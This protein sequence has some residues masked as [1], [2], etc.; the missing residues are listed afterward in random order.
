MF[1]LMF[2]LACGP[3]F[4]LPTAS[5]AQQQS[6]SSEKLV[7]VN[8]NDVAWSAAADGSLSKGMRWRTL[9]GK[10]G[11]FGEGLPDENLYFRQGEMEPGTI[12]PA[13]RHPSPEAWYFISG[14]AK[15]V[16]DGEEF[17]AEPGSAV[18]L[19]PNAVSSVEIVSKDIA[20]IV[21][22]NWGINCDRGVLTNKKY[23]FLGNKNWPQTPRSRLPQWDYTADTTR[24]PVPG[25]GNSNLGTPL[26]PASSIHLKHVNYHDV[27]W[28]E[29]HGAPG[30]TFPLRWITLV[31]D[32]GTSYA[33]W[34]KGLP[35]EDV[36]FGVGEAGSTA[37]Y[38]DHKHD[39]P[40]FYY[41]VSGRLLVKVDGHEFIAEP[42]ELIYHK[43]WAVHRS[44]VVSKSTA[45]TLW[46]DWGIKCDQGVLKQPYKMLG[47]F[48]EQ[49][50]HAKLP[51]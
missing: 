1:K 36:L 31:G 5:I 39:V 11:Y 22:I 41:V 25:T 2:C 33:G 48:P 4:L 49:P 32:V 6:E 13:H 37:V 47:A 20:Q 44:V 38:D 28:P 46:A 18:Y 12:Y 30:V 10:G 43:P 40:E 21:R 34:G 7:H 24:N 42:G 29:S 35:N 8:Q 27:R 26:S 17:L 19:K 15:W 51:R 14:R 23:I 3:L 50:P 45:V 16:V 9:L